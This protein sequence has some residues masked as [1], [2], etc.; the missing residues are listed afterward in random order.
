MFGACLLV[1]LSLT[2]VHGQQQTTYDAECISTYQ[3]LK[4]AVITNANN[5]QSLL[6][7]FYPPNQSPS[8]VVNVFYHIEESGSDLDASDDNTTMFPNF[9][10]PNST[11]DYI[12]QW[13]DSSTLLL[14]EVRLFQALSFYIAQLT[15]SE[16]TV[17]LPPFCNDS[18]SLWLLNALTVW[19]RLSKH[20]CVRKRAL[21]L[22]LAWELFHSRSSV[23]SH[24]CVDGLCCARSV[25]VFACSWPVVTE[26]RHMHIRGHGARV[27]KCYCCCTVA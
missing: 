12:F 19:V 25:D 8:H 27:N 24:H 2:V 1:V 13:V 14:T 18:D 3:D 10:E 17:V 26:R 20:A 15:I 9:E 6:L 11:A 22:V 5:T 4:N 23:V 7:G 21:Q 16:V